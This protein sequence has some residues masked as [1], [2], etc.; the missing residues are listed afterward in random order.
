MKN[1]I[2]AINHS[3]NNVMN[4]FLIDNGYTD[5]VMFE[6]RAMTA[7]T[8]VM[9]TMM[10]KEGLLRAEPFKAVFPVIFL[11]ECN[12]DEIVKMVCDMF[13]TVLGLVDK[14]AKKEEDV[15]RLTQ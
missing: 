4:R 13:K 12:E 8:H 2:W 10:M 5:S 9:F 11:Q 6:S 7:S 14:I 3:I 15:H 1:D